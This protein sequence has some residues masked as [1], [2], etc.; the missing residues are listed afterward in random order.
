MKPASLPLKEPFNQILEITPQLAAEWLE[1]NENN[2]PIT[3][4]YVAQLARDIKASRFPCTHQGIAFDSSGKLIDGQH[5][6]WAILEA[7][8]PVRMRVFFNESPENIAHIDGNH[9]RRAAERMTICQTLGTVR[10]DELATLRGMVG[11]LAMDYRRRTLHEE[12]ELLES[13]R[14]ALHFA[15]ENIPGKKP[16][17]IANCMIRA[18]VAR[19]W[20]CVTD[21]HPL[22]RFCEVLRTGVSL[23]ENEQVIVMLRNQLIDLRS[24]GTKRSA[25]Q[26]QYA[27]TSRA[28]LAYLQGEDITVLR[29][30]ASELFILPEEI[31]REAV[32]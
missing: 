30:S 23:G 19:A 15:H 1:Q 31:S 13:H 10:A 20:Y 4:N 2:R 21:H 28:L 24:Y 9:P 5:R 27:L 18:V 32:A 7:D 17:G 6:L 11:G 29:A 26:R 25:R 8:M 22:S 16:A 3:W 12:M 14:S